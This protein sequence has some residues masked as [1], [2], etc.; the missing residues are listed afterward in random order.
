LQQR[1]ICLGEILLLH[2]IF[3]AQLIVVVWKTKIICFTLTAHGNLSDHLLQFGRLGGF[4]K[5]LV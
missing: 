1:T 2:Q 3:I 4:Q 5:T